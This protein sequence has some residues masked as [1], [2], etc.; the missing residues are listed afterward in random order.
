MVVSTASG[1]QAWARLGVLGALALLASGCAAGV[2]QCKQ[3]AKINPDYV[4]VEYRTG[5]SA[6]TMPKPE[7]TQSPAYDTERTNVASV[8]LR[9]PDNCFRRGSSATTAEGGTAAAVGVLESNCGVP[10]QVLE[11][12][13]SRAGMRVLSW[14]TLMTI[15]REQ[16]VPVHVAAQ[17][18]G[19][20]VVFIVNEMYSG[21][22]EAAGAEAG[23][24]YKYFDATAQGTTTGPRELFERDRTWLKTFVRDHMGDDPK[25]RGVLTV[26]ARLNATAVLAKTGESIWFYN[27]RVGKVQG[28]KLGVK[29]LFAGQALDESS[30]RWWPVRPDIPEAPT[31]HT[32]RA[33][34]EE[35]F[36]SKTEVVPAEAEVLYRRVAEDFISRFKKGGA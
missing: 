23:A 16:R 6:G 26:Q 5:Q 12:V 11:S 34:S 17:Q 18:L 27:W 9:L 30:H 24:S 8:A 3:Q 31:L 33:T 29:F 25:A 36:S 32:D 15:E 2:P 14:S 19:A 10:L 22:L 13:L 4:L 7:I 28:A 20:D 35:E 1:Q 21:K